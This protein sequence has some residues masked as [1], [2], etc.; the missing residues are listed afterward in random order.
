MNRIFQ[1]TRRLWAALLALCLVL[2]LTLPV[3]AEGESS[4]DTTE[5]ETY[6]IGT[7][8]ELLQLADYCRLDSWSENR[9]V[10]LDA[11]LE[12]TGS[13]FSGIPSF[14]GVFLGQGH[15]ISGLSLVND[16]SVVGFFRYV[17][18]GA[19][20]RDLVVRVR[21]MPTGSRT[22][23]G[24]IAGS[25]AGTLHNC[26]FEGVSSGASIVGG[27]VGTNL[28]SG[29]IESC[30]TTGSVYGAHF[31]GGI[32]GENHGIIANSTN[33]ANVNTTVEQNDIDLSELTLGPRSVW[34]SAESI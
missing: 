27:I 9:T 8:D 4:A 1:L 34:I 32:A 11:D 19:N 26:R 25:N 5:K 18:K 24:G 29:V 28:A 17:Q 21:A 15:V 16:G 30:T 10:M 33:T 20:V 3:F 2:A 13:G 22:T 7:M 6:H 12:L 23:V 14:S 31:I